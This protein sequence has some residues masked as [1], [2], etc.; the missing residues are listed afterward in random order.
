MHTRNSSFYSDRMVMQKNIS[1]SGKSLLVLFYWL[2]VGAI[3]F[4]SVPS[5]AFLSARMSKSRGLGPTTV[6]N[7]TGS[8]QFYV[9]PSGVYGLQV[10]AWGAGGGGSAFTS[11]SA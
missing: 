6:F 11:C 5:S 1:L 7:Y 4:G 10:K 8:D 2:A 9:V 3:F